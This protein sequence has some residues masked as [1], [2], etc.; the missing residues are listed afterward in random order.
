M[1]MQQSFV[2]LI[3]CL[4]PHQGQHLALGRMFLWSSLTGACESRL[5]D[6]CVTE[7]IWIW[8]LFAEVHLYIFQKLT[9]P[10][11]IYWI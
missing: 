4:H 3:S 5:R 9:S 1:K 7:E 2:P 6:K 8:F 10:P 11:K